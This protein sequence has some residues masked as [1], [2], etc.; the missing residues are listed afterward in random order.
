MR[1]EDELFARDVVE[2]FAREDVA[3]SGLL[4]EFD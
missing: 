4:D 1:E 3:R 2:V